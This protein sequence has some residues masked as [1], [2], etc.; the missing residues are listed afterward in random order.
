MKKLLSTPVVVQE[1]PLDTVEA[2][3]VFTVT[4]TLPDGSSFTSTEASEAPSMSMELPV[5]TG[6][7]V[8]VSKLGFASAPSAPVD[9]VMPAMVRFSVPDSTQP[10]VLS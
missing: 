7:T 6:F 3:F 4:G 1:F 10:A 9:I 5:G 8:V 2:P